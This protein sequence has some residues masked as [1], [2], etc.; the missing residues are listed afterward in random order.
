[1]RKSKIFVLIGS[2]IL[3]L[4]IFHFAS[5]PSYPKIIDKSIAEFKSNSTLMDSLGGYDRHQ[6][7]YNKNDLRLDTFPYTLK[8][9]GENKTMVASGKI[10]DNNSKNPRIEYSKI[11]IKP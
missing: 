2:F 9:I 11:E 5:R 4:I 7:N 8:I 10:I 1:M 6:I 3:L